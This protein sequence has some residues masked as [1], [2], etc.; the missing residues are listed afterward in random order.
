MLTLTYLSIAS[1]LE[2]SISHCVRLLARL[3]A[4]PEH[5][6]EIIASECRAAREPEDATVVLLLEGLAVL[7]VAD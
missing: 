6:E 4:N 7:K 5:C 2:P 1:G 3:E